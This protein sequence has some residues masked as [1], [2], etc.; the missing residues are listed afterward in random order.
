MHDSRMLDCTQLLDVTMDSLGYTASFRVPGT[1]N[2]VDLWCHF[3]KTSWQIRNSGYMSH[4]SMYD[5]AKGLKSWLN[6]EFCQLVFTN[7][8]GKNSWECHSKVV[9]E[10]CVDN[11]I[12]SRID[13][14]QPHNETHD[15]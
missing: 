12:K 4:D 3:T 10:Y 11:W 7:F 13:V 9:I 14:A 5:E 15:L 1:A 6:D 8:A 2:L